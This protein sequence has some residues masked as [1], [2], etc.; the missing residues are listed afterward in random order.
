M[1]IDILR[2]GVPDAREHIC[3][4]V[5][6]ALPDWFGIPEAIEQYAKDCRALEM[7]TAFDG[8]APVGFL[9]LKEASETALDMHVLGVTIGYQKRGIGRRFCA[10]AESAARAGGKRFVTVMTLDD[11]HP[12]PYY[13]RTRAFY[14]A[15][16]YL[17]LLRLPTL[18]GE[19][20]P[21]LVLIK[22]VV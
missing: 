12:D 19:E 11:T 17:P 1:G 10:L 14:R 13:A 21:A 7:H 4:Q 22:P 8:G 9:A 2:L 18:W 15:M 6:S 20:N 16:G 3:R 5:L